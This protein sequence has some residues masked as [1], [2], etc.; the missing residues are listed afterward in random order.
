MRD[1]WVRR[2]GPGEIVP[3]GGAG[4]EDSGAGVREPR[5]PR[6]PHL[7]GGVAL[8]EPRTDEEL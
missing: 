7:S 6:P 5:R 8:E 2:R 3:A 1:W 4:D